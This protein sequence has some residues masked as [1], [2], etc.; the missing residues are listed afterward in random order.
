[1][2][3]RF[4]KLL[5]PPG[6][7]TGALAGLL[8]L[9]ALAVL[10]LA[11]PA[12]VEQLRLRAFD[13]LQIFR[14]RP[15][16][17]RVVVIDIDEASLQRYGQW[18]W[19]RHLLARLISQLARQRPLV[20]GMDMIFP[21]PD[22]L[23]PERVLQRPDLEELLAPLRAGL[24]RLPRNDELFA[25]SLAAAPVVLG[26][27][28]VLVEQP[29]AT[30]DLVAPPV[31]VQSEA[32]ALQ[33]QRF[34]DAVR[35]TAELDLAARGRGNLAQ[36]PER[37]GI[38]RR[39]PLL[40]RIADRLVPSLD[41]EMLRVA[42]GADRIVL[43]GDRA[44]ATVEV[45]GLRLPT[46]P[47]GRMWVHYAPHLPERFVSAGDILDGKLQSGALEGRILLVGL[48]G[49]GL[50]DQASSPLGEPIPGVEVRAQVLEQALE[51]SLGRLPL[52]RPPWAARAE[53]GLGLALGLVLVQL[54]GR[55]R[56]LWSTLLPLVLLPLCLGGSL[57][58]YLG[59]RLLIDPTFPL[60]L[61]LLPVPAVL[62]FNLVAADRQ[63]REQDADLAAARR[64]QMGILPRLF[65][66]FPDRPDFDLH[67]FIEPARA[68]G[69]D[70]YD[71]FL[72]EQQRLFFLI[73]D[74]AG[75]GVPASLFMALTKTLYK[76]SALRRRAAI[77][78]IMSEV[79]C[80]ISRENPE[81]MFVT[82]FAGIL[83]LATGELE[84]AN[85]GHDPPFILR[86]GQAPRALTS[87]GGPPLCA[88]DD[89]EYPAEQ[90]TLQ[91]GDCLVL[92]TDGVP[93]AQSGDGQLYSLTRVAAAL[94]AAPETAPEQV[95]ARL[96]ADVRRFA[97]GAE[98]A[99]DIAILA[100]RRNAAAV[101][102]P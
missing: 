102:V 22:R 79:N 53:V 76:A 98:P 70:L 5:P 82:V 63:Q 33:L 93:E 87:A 81:S 45:G 84:Y 46:E 94:A 25:R 51:T 64:I 100:L 31:L 47:D 44:G 11:D 85:A 50:L 9:A 18:P 19:P 74:V 52:R 95:I 65:P 38:V 6:R 99:D 34:D 54:A 21:E 56:P 23:S 17:L 4:R 68:V 77:G 96:I 80:E 35:S 66:A 40:V 43:R 10:R 75:K 2:S 67:A 90:T 101:S 58:C 39:V 48:T 8:V 69:G 27:A 37:D 97:D 13:R 3:S 24:A 83:D 78:Q 88:V 92:F 7:R 60:L 15:Q 41:L 28:G 29:P 36:P 14:P 91:V 42:S 1:M 89:F 73:G 62:G 20:I 16:K 57:V 59:P 26:V 32:L 71:F 61:L 86:P 72:M 49:I 55:L 30:T 12:P